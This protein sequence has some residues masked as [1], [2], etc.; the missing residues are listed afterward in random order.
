TRKFM[1]VI[2]VALFF[3]ASIYTHYSYGH[4]IVNIFSTVLILIPKLPVFHGVRLFGIN[5]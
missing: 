2:P 3:L 4:F 5:K 1:M